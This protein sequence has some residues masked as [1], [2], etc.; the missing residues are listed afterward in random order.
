MKKVFKRL[1]V[2]L[3]AWQV[4]RLRGRNDFKI[5]AVVGSTGKTSTKLTIA[6]LLGE[7]EKVNFQEGN[8][9]D[10]VSVPLVFFNR[11]LPPLT[12]PLA[13][14]YLLF[15]NE[16]FLRRPYPY[17]IVVLELGT[18]GPGQLASFSKYLEI[19]L[20][21]VTALSEEHME[22]FDSVDEVAK[23]ELS[24]QTFAKQVLINVDLCPD[25]YSQ[26][27]KPGILTYGIYEKADY[28][29]VINRFNGR[30]FSYS[31]L[32]RG[33]SILSSDYEGVS[34]VELYS[35]AAALAAADYLKLPV[36][37]FKTLTALRPFS[38]RMQRLVAVNN[39]L[40]IDDTYNASPAATKAA[41]KTL[42]KQHASHKIAIIGN[43]NELGQFSETAHRE[44]GQMCDPA[45]LDYLVTIGTDANKFLADEAEKKGCKTKRFTNPTEA[46]LFVKNLLKPNTVILAKGSQ[47]GVF[48]EE[49]VKQLLASPDDAAKLVR[50]SPKWYKIKTEAFDSWLAKTKADK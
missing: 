26:M 30:T 25:K 48:A 47:N 40:I 18:D 44:V 21:V 22:F 28:K 4:N 33:E 35:I 42:Y 37:K 5:I 32:K 13:W 6:K 45:Q 1:V 43:M 9:N 34:E 3:L 23:E 7:H 46:G 17:R 27:Y 29:L 14:A 20:L 36:I 16:V 12:N 41:I 39:S 2:A 19:D 50:Q 24:A 31:F 11:S 15:K 8:Y 38:G 49:A 10:I